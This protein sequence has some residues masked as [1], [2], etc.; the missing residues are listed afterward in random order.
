MSTKLSLKHDAGISDMSMLPWHWPSLRIHMV[1]ERVSC[2]FGHIWGISVTNRL[3]PPETLH[4]STSIVIT[5]N[6]TSGSV[7]CIFGQEEIIMQKDTCLHYHV[8]QIKVCSKRGPKHSEQGCHITKSILNNSG[9]MII[10][11]WIFFAQYLTAFQGKASSAIV[12]E[13]ITHPPLNSGGENIRS[14][15]VLLEAW[16]HLCASC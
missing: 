5:I 10:G 9:I 15:A 3:V 12:E 16:L 13:G 4:Q 1:L 7:S 2:G 14:P 6:E 8:Y 11:G